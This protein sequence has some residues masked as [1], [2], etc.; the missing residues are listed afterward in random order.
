MIGA[1]STM[2]WR[3]VLGPASSRMSGWPAVPP[4]DRDG[5]HAGSGYSRAEGAVD[6]AAASTTERPRSDIG[7]T[8][9]Q[10]FV[11][12]EHPWEEADA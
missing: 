4:T 7:A 10:P 1:I 11:G 2:A 5:G 3:G 8:R 6:E 9:A 12:S